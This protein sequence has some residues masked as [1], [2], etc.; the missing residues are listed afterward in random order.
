MRIEGD[1]YRRDHFRALA[2]RDQIADR[3]VRIMG[4][5]SESLRTL[6]AISSAKSVQVAFAVLFW[7]GGPCPMMMG[8]CAVTL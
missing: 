8:V 6:A 5:K 3:E 4:S 2:Q 1:G 7:A